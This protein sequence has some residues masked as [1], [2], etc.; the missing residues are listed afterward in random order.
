MTT[1]L[2]RT[3]PKLKKRVKTILKKM[4][5]D[6]S[7]AINLYLH[8]IEITETIPFPIRTENGFTPEQ[9]REILREV[10][11]AVQSG[12]SYRSAE[13]LH[14]DILGP[15]Y[16]RRRRSVSD[17]RNKTVQKGSAASHPVR[18]IRRPKAR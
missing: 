16:A 1:I 13:E 4:G 14:R 18:K 8:Q 10:E 3:D 5:L 9:E 2:I 17:R 12:R 11:E 7:T 15:N 6:V